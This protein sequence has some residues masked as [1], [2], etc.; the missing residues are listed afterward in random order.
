MSFRTI[1]SGVTR[2][3]A[4]AGAAGLVAAVAAQQAAVAQPAPDTPAPDSMA[5]GMV[6]EVTG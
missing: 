2:R 6:L 4:M 5:H 3:Q 1:L